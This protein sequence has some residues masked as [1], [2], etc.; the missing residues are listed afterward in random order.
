MKHGAVAIIDALGFRGIWDRWPSGTVLENMHALKEHLVSSV[1]AIAV[2]PDIQFEVTFLSDTIIIGLSLPSEAANRAAMSVVYVSD[3]VTQ[4]L[5]WTARSS[6]PLAYRG[7]VAYG[8]YEISAPF[9]LGPAIDEAAAHHE[10]AQGAVVWLLPSAKALAADWLK[11]QPRNT[12]LVVHEVPLKG[13]H[14]LETYTVSPVVQAANEAG[15]RLIAAA[16]LATFSGGGIDVAVK[17]QNTL[18]HLRS[19]F[20]WRRWEWPRDLE[21]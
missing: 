17:R 16:L 21:L 4:V 19:C 7:V 12:H 2:Q 1:K 3:L 11:E 18:H 20:A 13:G 15:A 10:L 5:A 14:A 9:I 8:E 6:T